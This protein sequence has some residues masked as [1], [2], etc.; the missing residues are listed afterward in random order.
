MVSIHRHKNYA[1]CLYSRAKDWNF[2]ANTVKVN[3]VADMNS[4]RR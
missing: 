3:T 2:I 4:V 1:V